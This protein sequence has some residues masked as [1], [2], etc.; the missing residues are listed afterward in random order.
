MKN[1]FDMIKMIKVTMN[2]TRSFLIVI[3]LLSINLSACGQDQGAK[4]N[5]ESITQ[6]NN[7]AKGVE[8]SP[9]RVSILGDSYST[10]K[11]YIPEGYIAWYMPVAKEGRPTDVT[12]VEQTWWDIFINKHGYE[13]EKNNS[14][15]GS[16]ICNTGYD[17]RDYSDRSFITRID[18]LGNPDIIIVYGGTNDSWA[19]SPI[20][21]FVYKNWSKKDLKKFRPAMSYLANGLKET[22]PKAQ[23]VFLING[24][25]ILKPE[26]ISSM[27]EIC[28]HYGL[29]YVMI[30]DIEK[31]SGHPSQRGMIQIVEQLDEALK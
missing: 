19:D 27:K 6:I 23:I 28:D 12:K 2:V 10:F 16:T 13:L 26:I 7:E 5:Q 24:E 18:K 15:S 4:A 20:G 30:N 31:M 22:Y 17:K 29:Q 8:Q 21:D 11:G 9:K 1:L 14:Y 3:L 25:D